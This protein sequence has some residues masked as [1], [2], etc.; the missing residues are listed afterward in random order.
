MIE[1]KHNRIVIG[2][3]K[4]PKDDA[5]DVKFISIQP[6][7][8]AKVP[9]VDVHKSKIPKGMSFQGSTGDARRGSGGLTLL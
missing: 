1:E 6:F 8:D 2:G 3:L 9:L 5:T 7:R 4:P